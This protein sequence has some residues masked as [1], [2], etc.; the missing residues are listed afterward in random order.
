MTDTELTDDLLTHI[1]NAT[2]PTAST[3]IEDYVRA[4]VDADQGEVR[5]AMMRL[6]SSGK[7]A[8]GV[9]PKWSITVR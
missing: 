7:I 1:R 8:V 9:G 2:E 4:H 3:L 5:R 6:I